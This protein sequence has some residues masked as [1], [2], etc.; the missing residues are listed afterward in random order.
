MD[1]KASTPFS[2]ALR[3]SRMAAEMLRQASCHFICLHG[4]GGGR[5][6]HHRGG[7]AWAGLRER[8]QACPHHHPGSRRRATDTS[9]ISEEWLSR[10]TRDSTLV[11]SGRKQG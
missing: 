1:S 9:F 5:K 11:E 2:Q 8:A 10:A 7:W 3:I 4:D 6:H